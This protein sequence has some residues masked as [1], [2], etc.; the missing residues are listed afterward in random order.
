M[1]PQRHLQLVWRGEVNFMG[2]P[3]H[4]SLHISSDGDRIY[5]VQSV[6]CSLSLF[7]FL[8]LWIVHIL[9]WFCSDFVDFKLNYCILSVC[10]T[11]CLFWGSD[12]ISDP[13]SNWLSAT[14]L[15]VVIVCL[16]KLID[17][18]ILYLL[19]KS[20]SKRHK[21]K[22]TKTCSSCSQLWLSVSPLRQ[23]VQSSTNHC[24]VP[25]WCRLARCCL[26]CR[27]LQ[28]VDVCLVFPS[29]WT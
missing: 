27:I 25:F 29:V 3:Q 15:S 21:R 23:T 28:Y 2:V 26:Y 1:C 17:W 13:R 24:C 19:K 18:N 7:W 14:S 12:L 5:I 22:K 11:F 16:S 10:Q 4:P 20:K 6:W 9:I 8:W